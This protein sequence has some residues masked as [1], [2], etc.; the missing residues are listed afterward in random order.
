MLEYYVENKNHFLVDKY[1]K[2]LHKF[3]HIKLLIDLM[4]EKYLDNQLL[5]VLMVFEILQQIKD[6]IQ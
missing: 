2:Y 3:L 4:L 6:L 1:N 5:N